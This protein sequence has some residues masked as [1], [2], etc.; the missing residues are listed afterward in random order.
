MSFIE[1]AL[2]KLQAAK[3]LNY[4]CGVGSISEVL[5]ENNENYVI[6]ITNVSK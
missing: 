4:T 2:Q 3:L 5:N 6:K 1:C